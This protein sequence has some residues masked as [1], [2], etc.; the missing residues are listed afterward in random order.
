M[1]TTVLK[2]G[3]R[4]HFPEGQR[5]LARQALVNAPHYLARLLRNRLICA[6][7]VLLD[8]RRHVVRKGELRRGW[9]NETL[10]RSRSPRHALKVGEAVARAPRGVIPPA[11]LLDKPQTHD[12]LQQRSGAA[13]AALVGKSHI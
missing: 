10:E 1:D 5:E 11:G 2:S 7:A 9:V 3:Q 8:L 4:G 13:A 12:I 6:P